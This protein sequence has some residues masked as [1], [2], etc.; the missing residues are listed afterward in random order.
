MKPVTLGYSVVESSSMKDTDK[1]LITAAFNSQ[2]DFFLTGRTRDYPYRMGQLK[3]LKAAIDKYGDAIGDALWRDLRK[4]PEEAYISE[5]GVVKQELS[6]QMCHLK[7]WM[8][9]RKV[10]TPLYLWPSR[11]SVEYEPL[12]NAL[13]IAPWNYPFQLLINPLIGALS[14]GCTAYL[15]PS[16]SAPA[17]A[18]VMGEMIG[19]FFEP[20][21][22]SICQGHRDVNRHLLELPFDFIFF[23]GSPALGKFVMQKAA[24]NLTPVVL[25]LGGKSPCIVDKGADIQAAARR[26]AWGKAIN[27]GQSCIAPDY[28]FVHREI[29]G[30]LLDAVARNFTEMF[31]KDP[32]RSP[33][34]PRIVDA[35]AVDRL[36]GLLRPGLL[37]SGGAFDRESRYFAPTIIDGVLPEHPLM[38]EEIFGPILPVMC[39]SDREEVIR[40]LNGQQKPLAFYYFGRN[41][42]GRD[43]MKRVSFGGGC[44][45]DTMLHIA[46]HHLPFGGVGNSGMGKYHGVESFR[47]FSNRKALVSAPRRFDLPF[48]YPPF[49]MFPLLKK[50]L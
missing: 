42:T 13:I 39:F 16:P 11:S 35:R 43:L 10:K 48:R 18:Q 28:L 5:I 24:E 2:R 20:A 37:H 46:N 17:F 6:H 9:P 36:G 33:L 50:F 41:R 47:V 22:V 30:D 1:T 12:G 7:K 32:S 49:R 27:A 25:E 31:G 23:T 4:S 44:L 29:K 19:E 21:A 14:A 34:Y 26:I 8:R 3:N 38:Q 15:K 45:N 40:Y